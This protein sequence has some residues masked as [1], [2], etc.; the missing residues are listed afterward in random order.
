M[1]RSR[2]RARI[3]ARG[4]RRFARGRYDE[5]LMEGIAE[6]AD[7]AKGSLSSYLADKR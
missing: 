3:L 1:R 2:L 7:V 6:A 5:V 4:A